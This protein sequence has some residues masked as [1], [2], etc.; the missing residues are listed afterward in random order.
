MPKPDKDNPIKEKYKPISLINIDAKILKKNLG[1]QILQYTE[2][3]QNRSKW[4][5]TQKYQACCIHRKWSDVIH[6]IDRLKKT[7][8]G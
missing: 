5:V 7:P 4:I 2:K 8:T 6:H 3:E 1:C